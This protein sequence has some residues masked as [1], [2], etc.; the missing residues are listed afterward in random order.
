MF[1]SA[2]KRKL[3]SLASAFV[4]CVVGAATASSAEMGKC[5]YSENQ[6]PFTDKIN[7]LFFCG[8]EDFSQFFKCENQQSFFIGLAATSVFLDYVGSDSSKVTLR[9]G[10]KEPFDVYF[11]FLGPTSLVLLNY[12]RTAVDIR[13]LAIL[14][15]ENN[16]IAVSQNGRVHVWNLTKENQQEL[17]RI[18]AVCGLKVSG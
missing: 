3:C 9:F 8:G 14:A 7:A 13:K 6:D 4:L 15:A 12:D 1:I 2:A 10:S 5:S 11:T 18:A 17:F 16:K